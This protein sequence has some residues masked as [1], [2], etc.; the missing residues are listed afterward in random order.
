[1]HFFFFLVNAFRSLG[2]LGSATLLTGLNPRHVNGQFLHIKW[3]LLPSQSWC[4]NHTGWRMCNRWGSKWPSLVARGV[5]DREPGPG[6]PQTLRT[7]SW[8]LGLAGRRRWGPRA[9][10]RLAADAED[11]SALNLPNPPHPFT[12]TPPVRAL[13]ILVNQPCY[14]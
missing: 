4:R 7:E 9:G 10:A 14:G 11:G 13:K 6:W 5:V 2:I 1:M 12:S 8:G 3:R